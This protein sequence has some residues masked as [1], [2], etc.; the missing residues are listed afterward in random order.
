MQELKNSQENN[1]KYD[2]FLPVFILTVIACFGYFIANPVMGIDDEM[3]YVFTDNHNIINVN[4]IGKFILKALFNYEF[5]PFV[6]DFLCIFCYSV[7]ALLASKIFIKCLPSFSKKESW[8]FSLLAVSFPFAGYSF[9]FMEHSIDVGFSILS[10]IFAAFL[11]HKYLFEEKKKIYITGIILSLMFS[12]SLYESGLFYFIL[13]SF[14]VILYSLIF[15]N[16]N[17]ADCKTALKRVVGTGVIVVSSVVLCHLLLLILQLITNNVHNRGKEDYLKYDFSSI[18]AFFNSFSHSMKEFF[19]IFLENL[20]TDFSC[21]II[22]FSVI[23]LLFNRVLKQN[24]T[25]KAVIY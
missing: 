8:I 23:T 4:R 16:S 5:A 3:I 13:I 12:V 2:Y 25:L 7:S 6:Y 1:K 14:F 22:L 19:N 18:H 24:A 20:H 21:K 15:E 10:S 11:F 17:R 9:I